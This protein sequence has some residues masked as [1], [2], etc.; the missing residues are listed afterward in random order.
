M[1]CPRQTRWW[2]ALCAAG[3]LAVFP[4]LAENSTNAPAPIKLLSEPANAAPQ[5]HSPVDFFRQLLAMSP[6]ERENFLTNKPVEVR[7]RILAKVA[8]YE[9]LGPDERELRL[10]ATELRWYLMP[11][12]HGSPTNRDARLAQIPNDMRDLVKSRLEQWEILPVPLQ[13]EFLDD[14]RAMRYFSHIDSTNKPPAPEPGWHHESNFDTS[15]WSGL[16]EDERGKI[17]AR[18]NQFFHAGGKTGNAQYFVRCGT[19]ANGKNPGGV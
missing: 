12:L 14:E 10:R 5:S 1:N 6:D 17:T 11:L 16:S 13:Q 3:Q 2:L 9:A 15:R 19:H 4:L 7:Q 18:V 8:E